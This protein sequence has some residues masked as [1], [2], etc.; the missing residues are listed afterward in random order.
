[1]YIHAMNSRN[2]RLGIIRELCD[3][4]N[5][6]AVPNLLEPKPLELPGTIVGGD[7]IYCPQEA[8]MIWRKFSP[9]KM[10]SEQGGK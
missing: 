5:L 2:S 7:A 3:H 4:V 8:L 10:A 1:M 9:Q 6:V